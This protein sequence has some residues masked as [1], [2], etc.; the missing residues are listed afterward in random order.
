M[1]PTFILLASLSLGALCV[2]QALASKGETSAASEEPFDVIMLAT[3]SPALDSIFKKSEA[4][5]ETLATLREEIRGVKSKLV[6]SL[7]LTQ[8]TPFKDALAD[9]QAKA[10][11]KINVSF[12]ENRWPTFTP[13]EGC[14]ENVRSSIASLNA[15]MEELGSAEAKLKDVSQQLAAIAEEATELAAEPK[16]LGL[17]ATKVP[18]AVVKSKKNVKALRAGIDVTKDLVAE[19]KSLV[20]DVEAVFGS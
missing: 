9:L 4:P 15:S 3:G 10:E 17:P 1:R 5:I 20:A 13:A 19:M 16:K 8:G 18:K 11:N 14:P 6:E 12:A 2:P 7:G